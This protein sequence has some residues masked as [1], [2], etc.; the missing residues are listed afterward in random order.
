[1]FEIMQDRVS[2]QQIQFSFC[3]GVLRGSFNPQFNAFHKINISA[4]S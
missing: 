3:R 1:M 4:L 2:M